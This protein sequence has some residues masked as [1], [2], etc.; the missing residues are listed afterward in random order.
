MKTKHTTP[1]LESLRVQMR[2]L[3]AELKDMQDRFADLEDTENP[4]DIWPYSW[5]IFGWQKTRESLHSL[6]SSLGHHG[7]A[8][9]AESNEADTGVGEMPTLNLV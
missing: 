8:Q 5:A 9:I 1:E 3:G 7:A 4:W 2:E 6:R